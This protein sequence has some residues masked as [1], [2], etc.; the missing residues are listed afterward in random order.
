MYRTPAACAEGARQADIVQN[1]QG[2]E[3]TY[4]HTHKRWMVMRGKRGGERTP[5]ADFAANEGVVDGKCQVVDVKWG[6]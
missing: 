3:H 4:L 1:E 5:D 2:A 6:R